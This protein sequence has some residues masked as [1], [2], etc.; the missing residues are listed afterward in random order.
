[1]AKHETVEGLAYEMSGGGIPVLLLHGFP[2]HR[3]LY[4]PVLPALAQVAL[5]VAVDLP[6]FGG[7]PALPQ[8]FT[9]EAMGE[10]VL[11]F[12]RARG[13]PRFV[14][15]GHSMG[16][17]VALEVAAQDPDAL[18]GLV[19]LSSHPF[20]DS[21]EAKQ[22]RQE[23]VAMIRQGRRNEFLT[24]FLQRLLAPATRQRFPR[25]SQELASM[26]S[27]V[28]D[29]VLVGSLEAMAGRRDHSTTLGKVD[30]PVLVMVGE[31]DALIPREMASQV[32]QLARQGELCLISETGHVPTLERPIAVA[33]ALARFLP[34]VAG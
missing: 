20:P 6:G 21:P 29:Q 13:L 24:G 2:F 1:M 14:L 11:A 15:V 18:L 12:A 26:A 23:G 9:L 30:V 4:G 19:L 16:G 31:E 17:Y 34:R 5:A 25:L 27:E 8:G 22:R 32:A 7:S 10:R 3:D 28:S 33:D